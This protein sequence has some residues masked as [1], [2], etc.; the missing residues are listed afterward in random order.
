M[1]DTGY[2]SL[3]NGPIEQ[4]QA[5]IGE[6]MDMLD[7]GEDF[8][9][10]DILGDGD[11]PEESDPLPL[12]FK[13][14]GENFLLGYGAVSEGFDM[15]GFR[16]A[17]TAAEDEDTVVPVE[18]GGKNNVYWYGYDSDYT[19]YTMKDDS[20]MV[21]SEEGWENYL[22]ENVQSIRAALFNPFVESILYGIYEEGFGIFERDESSDET[23]CK[24]PCSA[25][26]VNG[27]DDI[28]VI[29]VDENYGFL[30]KTVSYVADKLYMGYTLTSV[31]IDSTTLP[32]G[33]DTAIAALQ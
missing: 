27:R 21:Y 25:Y 20:L 17:F 33:Y 29:L 15:E 23:V 24:R 28:D 9:Y 1:V 31:E 19:F 8:D 32:E 26:W 7:S 16:V 4:L 10:D 14:E 30:A 22:D 18:I 5:V 6:I 11:E 12:D 2:G 13:E 3:L